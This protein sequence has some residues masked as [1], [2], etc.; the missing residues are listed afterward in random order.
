MSFENVEHLT[1]YPLS[2]GARGSKS[3]SLERF[4]VRAIY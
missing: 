4:R 2:Q 3:K 1:S